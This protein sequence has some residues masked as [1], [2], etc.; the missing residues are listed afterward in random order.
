MN[1]NENLIE[2]RQAAALFP[3]HPAITT[4]WRWCRK[5]VNGVRLEYFKAGRRIV[6]SVEAVERFCRAVAALDDVAV[7]PTAPT[8]RREREIAEAEAVLDAAGVTA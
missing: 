1:M 3:R 2:L 5:G 7:T 8:G 6:T 4:V